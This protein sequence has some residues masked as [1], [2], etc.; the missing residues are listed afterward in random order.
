VALGAD[1]EP[2]GERPSWVRA[3]ITSGELKPGD[4]LPTQ[5][6]LASDYG[7]SLQPVKLALKILETEGLVIGHQG[8][9]VFV[10]EAQRTSIQR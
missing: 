1:Q 4:H 7:A 8:K 5:A 2:C 3:R 10:S 6:Q 9:G